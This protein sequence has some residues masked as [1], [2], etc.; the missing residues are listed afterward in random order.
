MPRRDEP[1]EMLTAEGEQDCR[2]TARPDEGVKK[3]GLLQIK[4]SG[5][6]FTLRKQQTHGPVAD[7]L[8][9]GSALFPPRAVGNIRHVQPRWPLNECGGGR[10]DKCDHASP[11][12]AGRLAAERDQPL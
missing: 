12:R 5:T 6:T 10:A 9:A 4:V 7:R 3:P 11:V 8:W 1:E 2:A